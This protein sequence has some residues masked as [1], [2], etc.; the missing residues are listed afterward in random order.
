M[1]AFLRKYATAT[2]IYLP[3]IKRGVVDFAVSADWTPATGDVKVS[4]DG[5]AVANIGTL[6]TAIASGNGAFW[7]FTI[8]TGE[9]TGKLITITVSDAATKAVEDQCFLIETFGHAS[10]QYQ[11]DLSLANLPAN[12]TQLL[13]T[14]WLTP[15]TAG[16]PDVNTKTNGD[17]TGYTLSSVGIQ[18]IWDALTSALTTANSI[19]KWLVDKLAVAVS[20]PPTAAAVATAVRSELTTELGRIDAAISLTATATDVTTLLGRLTSARAGYLD[21]LNVGGVVASQADITALNQSASRRIIL[22]TVQQYERPETSST[23]YTIEART[24]DGDGAAVNADGTPTLTATGVVSGSLAANLSAASSPA[25]GVYRWTYSVSSAATSEQIRFDVSATLS[26]S[27]FTLSAYAQVVDLVSATWTSTD[28]ARLTAVYNKLPSKSYLTGTVNSDGDVQ[29]DE[30]TGV[31]A[32]SAGVGTLLAR[33]GSFAGS[34]L[35]TVLGFFRA[36]MRSDGALTPSDVGG[37]YDNATHSTQAAAVAV[38]GLSI[39][40]TAQIKTAMEADGSKLDHLW[41]MTEDD[42]GV[43]RLTTNALEQA[44]TGGGGGGGD[45]T[46]ANQTTILEKLDAIQGS[47]FSTGTDSL[48]VLSDAIGDLAAGSGVGA[49]TLTITVDD[50]T[51]PLEGATVRL[52]EGVT[53]LIATTNASGVAVFAVD[54]ATWA[55]AIT[56]DGYSFAP[57]TKVVAGTGSQTYSLSAV[58]ITPP[59]DPTQ[60]TVVVTIRDGAGVV[61]PSAQVKIRMLSPPAG[62]DGAAY[63]GSQATHTADGD[64]RI[65]TALVRNATYEIVLVGY[66]TAHEFT[67]TGA[68]YEIPDLVAKV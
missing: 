58:V 56:K 22:T 21:N 51:D 49:Y 30:A 32:D 47:G 8:A 11:A 17:K 55:V 10:A 14:P 40:T 26:A 39:P 31:P 59:T 24:Y 18:A 27:P 28:A 2:H 62:G 68:T 5:G 16:T 45:A 23:A 66:R 37:T 7:D 42:G 38:G 50:G 67:P 36:S 35:N 48:K 60:S 6:P 54:A 64:G 53:S 41:E 44:P 1:S 46:A 4:I 25:T 33:L 13:G 34:G 20:T 9:T 15:A 61:V 19:G 65:E 29:L 12:V 57:T 52:T 43:R 63:Q 3:I